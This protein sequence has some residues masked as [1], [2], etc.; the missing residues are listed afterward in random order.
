MVG[1]D[2][3]PTHMNVVSCYEKGQTMPQLAKRT[4]F[5]S[6]WAFSGGF[7]S[8]G[9]ISGF[10]SQNPKMGNTDPGGLPA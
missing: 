3:M 10:W 9:Y 4:I 7:E 5:G 1:P 8:Y 2:P 6:L